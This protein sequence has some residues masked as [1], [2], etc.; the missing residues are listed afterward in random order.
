MGC[1]AGPDAA[2]SRRGPRHH[3]RRMGAARFDAALARQP[4]EIAKIEEISARQD[5]RAIGKKARECRLL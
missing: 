1:A 2:T 3:L 5:A 4:W